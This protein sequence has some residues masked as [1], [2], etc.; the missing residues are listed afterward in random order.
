ML[1]AFVVA[2]VRC[3]C[4]PTNVQWHYRFEVAATSGGGGG[5]ADVGWQSYWWQCHDRSVGSGWR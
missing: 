1:G 2:V 4:T 3:H 5:G